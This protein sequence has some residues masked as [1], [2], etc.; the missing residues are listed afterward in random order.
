MSELTME[1]GF[2]THPGRV[3]ERNEDS[4]A[5]YAPYPGEAN[6]S[7]LK[8]LLLVADGMG[9]EGGGDQASRLA[10]SRLRQWFA[11]GEFRSWVTGDTAK[12]LE[13]ALVRAFHA[14]SDEVRDL[15]ETDPAL[16][17]AGS[18]LVAA[19]A[20]GSRI[21]VAHVGDSR[22]YRV[23]GGRIERLTVD[24]SWVQRQVDSGIL[25]LEEAR[26][27]PQRNVLTRSLG[28]RL[29]QPPDVRTEEL[30]EGDLFI[31]CTD[32]LFGG[33]PD[34]EILQQALATP[35]A[36]ALAD[37]LVE[38]GVQRDGSDNVTV[39]VGACGNLKRPATTVAAAASPMPATVPEM[40]PP[41]TWPW[42][43]TLL[44]ALAVGFA[45]GFLTARS[46]PQPSPPPVELQP[47]PVSPPEPTAVPT[48]VEVRRPTPEPIAVPFTPNPIKKAKSPRRERT[49]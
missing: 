21:T 36:Q 3:R 15:G 1:L 16:R 37:R 10:A 22:C 44:V 14:V 42:I 20:E 2:A 8:A 31:L 27:H 39:V 34:D 28:D 46:L 24:H 38:I 30:A 40:R 9:G 17:G 47:T 45:G 5:I 19:I 49:P 13:G 41:K 29:S 25:S 43:V 33:V 23:R 35:S 12:A 48:P 4:Y 32:G 7:G 11:S 18:T 6:R 26:H